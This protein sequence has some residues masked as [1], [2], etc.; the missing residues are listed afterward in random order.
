MDAQ[1][2][3]TNEAVDKVVGDIQ[4]DFKIVGTHRVHSWYAWAIVGI[5]FGMA[6]GIIYVANRSVKVQE[7]D[8]AKMPVV[9]KKPAGTPSADAFRDGLTLEK[10]L[11]VYGGESQGQL[12]QVKRTKLEKGGLL[13]Y[14]PVTEINVTPALT[15]EQF[16]ATLR[17]IITKEPKGMP[18]ELI[19]SGSK[20]RVLVFSTGMTA[21]YQKLF[22][23][24]IANGSQTTE[25]CNCDTSVD[26]VFSCV[27]TADANKADAAKKYIA[28]KSSDDLGEGSY[29]QEEYELVDDKSGAKTFKVA[30]VEQKAAE[31]G[32][33]PNCKAVCGN[34]ALE[35]N[36]PAI[37]AA[38]TSAT[39]GYSCKVEPADITVTEGSG[40][41]CQPVAE[42]Q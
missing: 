7:S 3:P 11:S 16:G 32:C 41:I 18:L 24:L 23:E 8:A 28:E 21:A 39:K 27:K 19:F 38:T 29:T 34:E 33:S 1:Q 36:V 10:V 31:S 37:V 15:A 6:L 25:R 42:A 4:K 13:S 12:V 35:K 14:I 26:L 20:N 2:Q 17:G 40:Q 30:L 22:P 9:T 5:V